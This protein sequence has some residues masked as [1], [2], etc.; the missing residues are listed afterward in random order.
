MASRKQVLL[1]LLWLPLYSSPLEQNVNNLQFYL[2]SSADCNGPIRN[3]YSS[4]T[5]I[6][7]Q[8]S[9]QS[10]PGPTTCT[11]ALQTERPYEVSRFKIEIGALKIQDCGVY[12]SIYDGEKTQSTLDSFDCNKGA[13]LSMNYLVTT[14]DKVTFLLQRQDI[15]NTA[16]D[17]DI[18][19]TPI[20][21]GQDPGYENNNGAD[22]GYNYHRKFPTE[23]IVGIVGGLFLIIAIAIIIIS[24]FCYRKQKGLSRRWEQQP[25]SHLKTN[26]AYE[27]STRMSKSDLSDTS[28]VWASEVSKNPGYRYPSR[29]RYRANS[30]YSD[31]EHSLPPKRSHSKALSSRSGRT[32]RSR[33]TQP[34]GYYTATRNSYVGA[35]DDHP[36]DTYVER[37]VPVRS[38]HRPK[39]VPVK[40][41]SVGLDPVDLEV[42]DGEEI[43]ESEVEDEVQEEVEEEEEE[44]AAEEEEPEA[45]NVE[46]NHAQQSAHPQ[47]APRGHGSQS[48]PLPDSG[49]IQTLPP[50][51]TPIDPRLYP[52]MMQDPR[53]MP[54]QY[55]PYHPQQQFMPVQGVPYQVPPGYPPPH[56]PG[57]GHIPGQHQPEPVH[58]PSVKPT[59]PPI[60]SYLVQRG[61]TPLDGRHSPASMS[62]AASHNSGKRL[63]KEDSD[64][65]NLESGV[66][67]MR[68]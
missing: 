25:L 45:D 35:D 13:E 26:S 16:Y 37:E 8:G 7:G 29:S 6:K 3:V 55:Q 63:L 27:P 2:D 17:I 56:Y 57:Q 41:S 15:R 60:Y 66:E 14:G 54:Q 58:V 51:M 18:V 65:G 9:T 39:K 36:Q 50:H 61:Y 64:S 59:D 31:D 23:A 32:D 67:F 21:A 4:R 28:S 62:S 38:H 43:D 68:R 47:P 5:T 1:L 49:H 40:T 44:E 19:V 30:E 53:M 22:F 11:I 12:F 34:P 10:G 48:V 42:E 20:T 33:E 46:S 52:Q 24:I